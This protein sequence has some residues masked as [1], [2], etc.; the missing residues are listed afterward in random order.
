MTGLLLGLALAQEPEIED[1]DTGTTEDLRFAPNSP[2]IGGFGGSHGVAV[3]E[4]W[5]V[6][7]DGG[8]SVTTI[9][10]RAR[11]DRV[12]V[13]VGLPFAA[14]ATPDGRDTDLGNLSVE[15]LYQLD[16]GNGFQH[17]AGL[18]LRANPGGT[19]YTWAT[20]ADEVWP[21]GG[22][23]GIWEVRST[24]FG[25]T[26]FLG[27]ASLGVHGSRGFAP[28]PTV[29]ARMGATAAVDQGFGDIAGIVAEASVAYWDVAPLQ[30]SGL[31]RVEPV[32]GLQ[33][34]GGLVLPMFTWFGWEPTGRP[35]GAREAT[36][37]LGAHAAL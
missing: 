15:G 3:D 30:L 7:G 31:A 19:P 5:V 22:F 18:R 8:T 13:S 27:R 4:K 12:N 29:W 17:A 25:A 32:E 37:L 35:G 26:T 20:S 1:L 2:N 36:L 11:Y 28:V 10:A 21:G 6:G 24:E 9:R 23:D 34:R 16:D 33:L 14:Y